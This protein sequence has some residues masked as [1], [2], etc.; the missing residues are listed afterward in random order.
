MLAQ[1]TYRNNNAVWR[2]LVL[3]RYRTD[4]TAVFFGTASQSSCCGA[5]A[6]LP[7][8]TVCPDEVGMPEGIPHGADATLAVSLARMGMG[9][10][11]KKLRYFHHRRTALG[12]RDAG[13]IYNPEAAD[14]L[15]G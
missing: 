4:A 6:V 8:R 5:G 12:R 13:G 1:T 2:K 9:K 11:D 14:V 15:A 10:G 3:R 7:R